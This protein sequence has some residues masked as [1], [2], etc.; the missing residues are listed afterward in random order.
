MHE[1]TEDISV[2]SELVST[3]PLLHDLF[4]GALLGLAVMFGYAGVQQIIRGI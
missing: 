3:D 2:V 4:V 1:I